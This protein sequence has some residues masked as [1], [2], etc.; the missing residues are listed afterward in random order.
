MRGRRRARKM[1]SRRDIQIARKEGSSAANREWM[2]FA[3]AAPGE[4]VD[5]FAAIEECGLW[6]M[7]QPLNGLLGAFEKVH[8]RAGVLI[9]SDRPL[10]LQR[11]TAAH[12]FGHFIL[13]HQLSLDSDRELFA[14]G[15]ELQEHAAQAFAAD[16]LMPLPL[17]NRAIDDSSGMM[18]DGRFS[19]AS[20]YELSLALGSSYRAM[21]T[22]LHVLKKISFAQA[23]E[24]RA[25]TPAEI[26][27]HLRNGRPASNP[28]AD[29]W[30]VDL[31]RSSR[32]LISVRV[33]DEI[34]L[35]GIETPSTGFRWQVD[36]SDSIRNLEFV[37]D[38]LRPRQDGSGTDA[39]GAGRIRH[40]AWRAESIGQEKLRL[41]EAR[42]WESNPAAEAYELELNVEPS[43]AGPSGRGLSRKQLVPTAG[44]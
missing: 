1:A 42:N 23:D 25:T 35:E 15:V 38:E 34:V 31:A 30:R 33:E 16:F 12:E 17:V 5:V 6:L 7:F 43:R 44:G 11:F 41:T 20:V 21:I 29:V 36:D 9:N 13:G 2:K 19:P 40:L 22:Q 18:S 28:R 14:S 4:P 8:D 37:A 10:S 39:I 3:S 24:L 26:K 27:R 32:A